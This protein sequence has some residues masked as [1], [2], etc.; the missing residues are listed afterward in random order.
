M[1]EQV[2]LDELDRDEWWDVCRLVR[3]DITREEF[4]NDWREFAELKQR[5]LAQ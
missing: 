1:T 4:E 3:P 2:R 5:R